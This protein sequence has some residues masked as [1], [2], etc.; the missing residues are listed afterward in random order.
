M[1]L[2][3]RQL[4]GGYTVHRLDAGAPLPSDLL[5]QPFFALLRSPDELSLC[6]RS[7]FPVSSQ[8][9]ETDWACLAVDGPLAF[10]MTGVIAGITAPLAAAGIPVF[11][12]SSYDTDYLLIKQVQAESAGQVL[13]RNNIQV[14]LQ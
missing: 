8:A 7:T 4:P 10:S 13:R 11:V 12:V 9:S 3:L 6:C 2:T 1:T 5:E 14:H